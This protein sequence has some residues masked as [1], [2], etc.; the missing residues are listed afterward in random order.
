[1]KFTVIYNVMPRAQCYY[2]TL[3]VPETVSGDEIKRAYKNLAP[4]WHPDKNL[5]GEAHSEFQAL[6]KTYTQR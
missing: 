3:G 5:T 1:M 2:E 4:V 6:L